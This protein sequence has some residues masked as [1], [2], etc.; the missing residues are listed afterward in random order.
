MSQITAIVTLD[1]AVVSLGRLHGNPTTRDQG[2][3]IRT[4]KAVDV[5]GTHHAP[6]ICQVKITPLVASRADP[7]VHGKRGLKNDVP[8]PFVRHWLARVLQTL[9]N[10][11]HG[12][13]NI[14]G[15]IASFHLGSVQL[16]LVSPSSILRVAV[17]LFFQGTPCCLQ[18]TDPIL[19][20][21]AH[22]PFHDVVGRTLRGEEQ[23]AEKVL[24]CALPRCHGRRLLSGCLFRIALENDGDALPIERQDDAKPVLVLQKSGLIFAIKTWTEIQHCLD[25]VGIMLRNDTTPGVEYQ[26]RT[27]ELPSLLKLTCPTLLQAAM[28][29]VWCKTRT[30]AVPSLLKVTYPTFFQAAMHCV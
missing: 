2:R 19:S 29:C 21:L 17:V 16:F 23:D 22:V 9:A 7:L 13:Q 12:V 14:V 1:S 3:V 8:V 5:Q 18:V 15:T 10:A 30:V 28:H 11:V 24:V 6:N 26:T 27:V 20:D 4:G 25:A